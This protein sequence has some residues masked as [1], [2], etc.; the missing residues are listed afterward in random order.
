[1]IYT[2]IGVTE[3]FTQKDIHPKRHSLK[4]TFTQ[5]DIHS[6]RHSLKE[7]CTQRDI[8]SKRHSLKETRGN[9]K[10]HEKSHAGRQTSHW[11]LTH[12]WRHTMNFGNI[13]QTTWKP[14]KQLTTHPSPRLVRNE[15]QSPT[16]VRHT[17]DMTNVRHTIAM[18]KTHM[19][20]ITH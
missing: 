1:M 18:Q 9:T 7:T 3:T 19:Q 15:P 13:I 14:N 16:H 2:E 8:H 5:R 12:R 17:S 11:H 4:E 10:N 20:Q 6:K